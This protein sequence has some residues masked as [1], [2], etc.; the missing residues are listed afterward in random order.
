MNKLKVTAIATTLAAVVLGVTFGIFTAFR[1]PSVPVAS[2]VLRSDGF[3]VKS[4]VP[5]NKLTDRVTS[6]ATG[7]RYSSIV[8]IVFVIKPK[9]ESVIGQYKKDVETR[10]GRSAQVTIDGDVVRTV[11]NV[12]AYRFMFTNWEIP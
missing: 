3:T 12:L 9:F 6:E 2:D 11:M 10:S 1:T 4:V 8:E 5:A 7:T